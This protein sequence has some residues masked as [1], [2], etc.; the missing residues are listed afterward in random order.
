MG[1][2][3]QGAAAARARQ[4]RSILE[5]AERAGAALVELAD[6][7]DATNGAG[8]LGKAIATLVGDR[9]KHDAVQAFL[10]RSEPWLHLYVQ[11]YG[12]LRALP[13]EHHVLVAG[14]LEGPVIL[15]RRL[16]GRLAWESRSERAHRR[17]EESTAVRTEAR[18]LEW[19]W[20]TGLD[21]IRLEWTAQLAPAGGGFS[22]LV[23]QAGRYGGTGVCR[24]GI[25]QVLA[26]AGSLA[27]ALGASRLLGEPRA[28]PE[29]SERSHATAGLAEVGSAG[30][31]DVG[32]A[33][34]AEVASVPTFV[35]PS[36]YGALFA[37]AVGSS[38]AAPNASAAPLAKAHV[39]PAA[40]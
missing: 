8:P 31:A 33:G 24:V 39:G 35:V 9:I 19:S 20:Q 11:P 7:D 30:L 22:H 40:R 28:L 17:L 26:L 32:A 25:A 29:R 4:R 2:V 3:Q 10:L 23:V 37:A 6:T 5:E 15:R 27:R 14:T 13:G 12:G 34:L 1:L 16:L 18:R 38:R 36:R 21:E